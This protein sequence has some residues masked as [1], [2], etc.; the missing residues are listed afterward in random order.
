MY[1]TMNT[2][3]KGSIQQ[4]E[5]NKTR[6]KCR[7][8]RLRVS[9]GI[10]PRTGRYGQKTRVIRGT[11]REA[12]AALDDFLIEL[13]EIPTSPADRKITFEKLSKEY[14]DHRLNMRQISPRTASKIRG[15]L[16]ALSRHIGKCPVDKLTPYMVQQ[17][18]AEMMNGDSASGNDLSGTYVN[19]II[20]SASTMMVKYAIPHGLASVNVFDDIE[21]PRNDTKERKPLTD[22]QQDHVCKNCTPTDHRYAAVI[23]ALL[24]GLRLGETCKLTWGNVNL[25]DGYLLLPDTKAYGSRSK[26]TPIQDKLVAFLLTWKS[27]QREIMA[28]RYVVQNDDTYVCANDLGDQLTTQ[29]LS[30]WW[31]RNREKLGCREVHF[32]D[33]RHTFATNLARKNIHPKAI[34]D[35]LRQKDE[36]VAMRIYTHVSMEQMKNA[37][38]TLND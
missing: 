1:L 22:E 31:R 15:H 24:A 2:Q 32:H 38:N 14:I 6:A 30:R 37:I 34:Q 13:E 11:Y 5:P 9:T 17:A 10:N 23:L 20:Q 18:I 4:L 29:T 8:W 36:R 33:L 16:D 3:G 27:N 7:K 12:K 28:K 26:A 21:R 25:I 19:M 35:L